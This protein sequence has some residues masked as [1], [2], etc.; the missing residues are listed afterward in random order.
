MNGYKIE[1]IISMNPQPSNRVPARTLRWFQGIKVTVRMHP[2]GICPQVAP[3]SCS[4]QH[5]REEALTPMKTAKTLAL[6]ALTALMTLGFPAA[7]SSQSAAEWDGGREQ[8]TRTELESLAERLRETATSTAYSSSLRDEAQ[9]SVEAI[10]ERLRN[11]DFKVGDQVELEVAGEE[12]MSQTLTVRRGPSIDIPIVGSVSLDGVLRS[13]LEEHLT[14]ELSQYIRSPDVRARTLVRLL[15]QGE[16]ADPGYYVA[17]AE[18]LISDVLMLAG[19]PT[20]EALLTGLRV[21][22]AGA[23]IWE[24]QAMETAV[25]QGRTLDQLNLQAGDHLIV[26]QEVQRDGIEWLRLFATTVGPLLTVAV[27][28]VTIF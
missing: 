24:G 15:V 26:P 1:A 6:V 19:G 17:P 13:E 9:R 27:A 28:L 12:E 4:R 10:E 5:R 18:M 14:E 23:R 11:G 25:I 2:H 16:V 21:E 3:G 8:L 20:R 22:R 7:A